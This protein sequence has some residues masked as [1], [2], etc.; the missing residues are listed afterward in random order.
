MVRVNRFNVGDLVAYRAIY[1]REGV[2]LVVEA[3]LPDAT[4]TYQ[5]VEVSWSDGES[6]RENIVD[7]TLLERG[8]A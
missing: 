5:L 6:F 8:E 1:N 3:P 2:G 7:F 4:D